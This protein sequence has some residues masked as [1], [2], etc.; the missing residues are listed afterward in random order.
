MK[1]ETVC[2]YTA[3][4]SFVAKVQGEIFSQ[5]DAVSAKVT[6]VCRID[7]LA[8][9]DKFFMNNPLKVKENGE[10]SLDFALHLSRFF[11]LGEFGHA[12]QTPC[13]A[14]AFFPER[15]SNHCLG[16]RRIL[17]K[18]CTTFGAHSSDASRNRIRPD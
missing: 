5:F 6:V 14:H 4:G 17:S 13:T 15:L 7:C 18:I 12:I 16:L 3:T 11:G 1:C 10:H 9:Q 8:C 2:C